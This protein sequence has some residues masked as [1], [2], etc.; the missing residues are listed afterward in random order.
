MEV[1]LRITFEIINFFAIKIKL[2]ANYTWSLGHIPKCRVHTANSFN[3]NS[4]E[5]NESVKI[6]EASHK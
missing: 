6:I 3:A 1:L 4:S 2:H 5:G